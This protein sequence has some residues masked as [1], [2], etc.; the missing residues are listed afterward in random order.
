M[1]EVLGI[2]KAITNL[3]EAHQTLGI[4]PT[5]QADFFPEWLGPFPRS[6]SARN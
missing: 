3:S 2:T 1:A 4:Q 6:E 5:S